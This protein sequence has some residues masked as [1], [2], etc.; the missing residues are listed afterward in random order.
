MTLSV[1]IPVHDVERTLDRSLQS[2]RCS[3]PEEIELVIVDDGSTDGTGNRLVSFIDGSPFK[4]KLI[5]QENQGV[6]AARNTALDNAEGEYLVFLDAD[7]RFSEGAI[8]IILKK[9]EGGVDILGWDWQTIYEGNV[10]HFRQAAYSTPEDALRNLMG[11]TM[12]WNLWL[13]A[14]KRKMLVD[15][16]I[17]FIPGADMGEDMA[18]MLKAF[19]CAGSLRQIHSELYEYNAPGIASVSRELDGKRRSQVTE[20]LLAAESF[21]ID[22]RY[23]DLYKT[24]LPFLKLYIKRP[25]LIGKSREDFNLWYEWFPESNAFSCKNRELPFH[26]HV[27]QWAASKRL[28]GLVRIYN[29]L[30]DRYSCK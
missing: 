9:L 8:D 7:D 15:N 28:W 4:C 30:F 17:R 23:R 16:G 14:V 27:L 21:L 10:R 5:H 25:L 24:Y 26:T 29:W 2:I 3:R 1:I 11:G 19:A 13:F 12:K 22:S 20:N 6:A 18:F